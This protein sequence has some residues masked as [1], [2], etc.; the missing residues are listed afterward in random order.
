[1]T[2]NKLMV[3]LF[4]RKSIPL[5]VVTALLV[6]AGLIAYRQ[7]PK[8][9]SY[10][11]EGIKYQLGAANAAYAKSVTVRVEGK[12]KRPLWGQTVFEGK[13][14]LDGEPLPKEEDGWRLSLVFHD[15]EGS[16]VYNKIEAGH[17]LMNVYGM[18]YINND[19]SGLTVSILRPE[20]DDASRK[21][22]S[23]ADGFM[24]S[25]PASSR[26]EALALSNK[27]YGYKQPN[28]LE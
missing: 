16:M 7:I 28:P 12:L 2:V 25:A 23:G 20:Q 8:Q 3:P 4:A 27:L 6:I 15:N 26:E 18:M 13:V 1:M 17:P 21:S 5:L 10:E 24:I 19:M 14:S 22:W 11:M 9:V